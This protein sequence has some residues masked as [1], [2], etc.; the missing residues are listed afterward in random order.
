M[1]PAKAGNHA[2]PPSGKQPALPSQNQAEE[3]HTYAAFLRGI[4][5]GGH[6]RIKMADLKAAFTA[7]GFTDVKTLLASGN[8]RFAAA[9]TDAAAVAESIRQRLQQA[10][11]YEIGVLV[12]TLAELQR[13]AAADPFAG[14]AVTPQ[15][16]LYVTFLPARPHGAPTLPDLPADSGF[17]IVRA[18]AREVCSVLTLSPTSGTLD[19][20]AALEKEFG[21][22]IT[23]RTWNTVTCLLD[24]P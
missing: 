4:N 2:S 1:T 13:L 9:E 20:M 12:R 16:R 17:S 7:Q 11:G 6:K 24:R 3:R 19:L 23:T 15:T 14:V 8:V 18:T 21:P 22:T 5:V 10:F